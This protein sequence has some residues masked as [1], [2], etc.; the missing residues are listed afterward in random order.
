IFRSL[1]CNTSIIEISF[2]S[3]DLSNLEVVDNN[4]IDVQEDQNGMDSFLNDVTILTSELY[5]LIT[6]NSF[7]IK[8]DL[9]DCNI[10]ANN[11]GMGTLAAIG[12]A[13]NTGKTRLEMLHL[14]GNVIT[15]PDRVVIEQG[16]REREQAIKELDISS[17]LQNKSQA[18]SENHAKMREEC[19][20][21]MIQVLLEVVPDTLEYLNVSNNELSS[22][23]E[24][25][26]AEFTDLRT[27]KMANMSCTNVF[28]LTRISSGVLEELELSGTS[29]TPNNIDVLSSFIRENGSDCLK[30]L[31]IENCNVNS[32][33]FA[34]ICSAICESQKLDIKLNVGNNPLLTNFDVFIDIFQQNKTPAC[35]SIDFIEWERRRL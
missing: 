9:T 24:T 34:K 22:N 28:D 4:I 10:K 5:H 1:R 23:M 15:E 32:E 20:F 30:I 2:K 26:L 33:E 18:D 3:V 29:L 21:K 13:I 35:L 6:T 25:A 27:F 31:S 11:V 8:L 12:L 19:V 16:I 14:G 7:L 17:P